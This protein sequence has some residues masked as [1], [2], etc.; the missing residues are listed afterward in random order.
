MLKK[1]LKQISEAKALS[2]PNIAQDLNTSEAIIEGAIDQ[3]DRMGYIIEDMGSPTCETKCS[4]CS[5]S[6]CNITPLKTVSI[7]DKGYNLLEDYTD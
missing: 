6:S 1:V 7:T 4:G 2:I 5:I 3:L